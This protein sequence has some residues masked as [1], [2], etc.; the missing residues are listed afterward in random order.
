MRSIHITYYTRVY[1]L[2]KP[3]RPSKADAL[4]LFYS[5][6]KRFSPFAIRLGARIIDGKSIQLQHFVGF[7]LTIQICAHCERILRDLQA[8]EKQ[9]ENV[10]P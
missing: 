6:E 1:N 10:S 4:S 2:Q 3:H 9:T 7:R 5:V 8:K